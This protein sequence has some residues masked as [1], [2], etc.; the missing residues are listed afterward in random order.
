MQELLTQTWDM[1]IGREHGPLAF[2][3]VLQPL[4][5]ALLAIRAGMKD[6]R[7]GRPPHGWAIATD[8]I[9]RRAL[10]RESWHD[11]ARLFIAAV[12]I[13]MIYEVTVFRWIYPGQALIVAMVLALPSYL[14]IRGPANRLARFWFHPMDGPQR[15]D[16]G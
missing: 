10:L 4:V 11:V 16:K 7:A 1:L 12:I 3:L 9:H 6:A 15:Q 2:R 8:P 5:G 13:D 14:L